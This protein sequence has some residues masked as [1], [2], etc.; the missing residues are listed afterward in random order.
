MAVRLGL[1]AS[2]PYASCAVAKG[3][4]IVAAL[5]REKAIENFPALI[6][7]TLAQAQVSL[8]DIDEIVVCIGP[9]SQTGVR[10]AVVTGNAL[11]LA[12][13]KP[14][15]GV[16]TTDA[17]AVLAPADKADSIAV[18]AGRRRWYVENY[19]WQDEKLQR[20]GELRLQDELPANA[21]AALSPNPGEL[22]SCAYGI[23]LVAEQQRH[24]IEQSLL[25]EIIPYETGN[26]NII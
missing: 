25:S 20:T 12:L 22:K 18:S 3:A 16:L 10:A 7:D 15:S 9:G 2:Q 11:A 26:N 14:I 6:R 19:H 21:F 5:S 24:L 4:E 1:D 17:A 8:Q 23:L 13:D